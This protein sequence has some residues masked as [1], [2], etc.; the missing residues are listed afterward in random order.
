MAI[1]I[2]APFYFRALSGAVRPEFHGGRMTPEQ[3]LRR[4]LGSV[5]CV[6]LVAGA[7]IGP[8][9]F[10]TPG[11]VARAAETFEASLLIWALGGVVSL[12]GAV[13]FA[14][15]CSAFPHSGGIYVFLREAY[16]QPAA[17]LYGWCLFLIIVPGAIATLASTFGTGLGYF[18]DISEAG[19]R[20]AAVSLIGLLAAANCLGIR[21]AAWVQN[22][23]SAVKIVSLAGIAAVLFS[24]PGR[25]FAHLR[26]PPSSGEPSFGALGIALVAALWAYDGWHLL[27]YAAGEVRNPQRNLATGLIGGTL[28]VS[29]LYVAANLA[30]LYILSPSAIAGSWRTASDAMESV[31]GTAGAA[32]VVLATLVFAAGV[33]SSYLMAGPRV[34]LAMAQDGLFFRSAAR[35]HPAFQVPTAAVLLCGIWAGVLTWVGSFGQLSSGGAFAAWLFHALGGAAVIALRRKKPDIPRPFKAWGYPWTPALFC[36]AALTIACHSAASNLRD[37]AWGLAAVISGL[38]AYWYWGRRNAER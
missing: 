21:T 36:L 11:P 29:L 37:S 38:P 13:A 19:A 12:C 31:I 10:L 27:T 20:L 17:F 25:G 9:I 26:H 32:V 33:I 7:M 24:T 34:F 3:G 14:E 5:D 22:I 30:Y 2:P 15:L 6:L 1:P 23:L 35:I 28:L 8:G 4:V 18:V 16:G